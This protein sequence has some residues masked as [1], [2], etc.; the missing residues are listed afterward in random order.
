MDILG[1]RLSIDVARQIPR[2]PAGAKLRG[3]LI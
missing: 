1:E 3:G 2:R